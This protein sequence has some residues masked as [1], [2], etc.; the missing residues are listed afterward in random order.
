MREMAGAYWAQA[1]DVAGALVSEKG[2]P[3]RTAHQIV[4]IL[5]RLSYE[6][7]IHPESVTTG[8]LD[9][10]ALEYMGEPVSLSH[11]A[12]EKA[13]DP[14]SFVNLRTLFGGPAPE[15]CLRRLPEFHAQLQEDQAWVSEADS[16]LREAAEKLERA[17][18]GL[19]A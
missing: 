10:A 18:D 2:L 6:R 1:T 17:I 15:E 3:W 14:V 13:L 9:E 5:V 11:R 12:L 19:V 4:G 7:E 8:L 16:G